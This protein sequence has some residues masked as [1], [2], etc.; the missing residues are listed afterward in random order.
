MSIVK[1]TVLII[2]FIHILSVFSVGFSFAEKTIIINSVKQFDYAKTCYEKADYISAIVEFK[3]FLSFFPDDLK[4]KEAKFLIGKSWY[5]GGRFAEAIK[6]FND[7]S[8]KDNFNG[9]ADNRIIIEAYFMQARCHVSS[10]NPVMAEI[11]LD[12][13]IKTTNSTDEKDRAKN[14]IAWIRLETAKWKKSR[15]AFLA[16]GKENKEKYN[17]EKILAQL[18]KT[19]KISEKSPKI[20]GSLA[21]IPGAGYIYNGRYQDAFISFLLN[22]ALIYA[23]YESFE[24]EN[25]ALGGVISF[26]GFG[27]YSGSI[28]GSVSS[29]HKYNKKA[30][31]GFIRD[32]KKEIPSGIRLGLL[33]YFKRKKIVLALSCTF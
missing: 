33:P 32:L 9:R 13:F 15:E 18:E 27:F 11:T 26:V 21:V 22:S 7:I 2:A 31:R 28:Y 10:G 12:N 1:K 6:V 25:Y 16:I 17:V 30:R 24:H 4:V 3:K 20:A 29:A 19:D 5:N 23:A 14:N 8:E